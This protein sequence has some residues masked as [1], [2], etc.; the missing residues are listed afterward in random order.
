MDDELEAR[1]KDP[2]YQR[3]MAATREAARGGYD[4]VSMRDL[5]EVTRMSLTSVYQF[6][7]SKDHLIAEAHL[8][9][10]EDFRRMLS[11]GQR[12]SGSVE[13]R[14]LRVVRGIVNGLERDEV[15]TRTLMRAIYS[16]D[17][18]AN[19]VSRSLGVITRE[20]LLNAID[21]GDVADRDAVIETLGRVIDSAVYGWL[22]R[23]E[24]VA[25]V[26]TVLEQ[27]VHLLVGADDSKPAA[28]ATR[29]RPAPAK[30]SRNGQ[31]R[32]A[33]ST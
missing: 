22:A 31:A 20:M 12:R 19:D 23:G 24:T 9:G 32:P 4:A 10:M 7:S 27:A 14:V 15:L 28:R 6:C 25:D 3:L 8:E 21:E 5:A 16:L 1:R 30:A 13:G 11:S 33:K 2:R 26:R 29:R 17:A 18:G